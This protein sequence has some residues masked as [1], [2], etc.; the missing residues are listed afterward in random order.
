MKQFVNNFIHWN[1]ALWGFCFP[2]SNS[3]HGLWNIWLC[4]CKIDQFEMVIKEHGLIIFIICCGN[5]KF[6]KRCDVLLQ[7]FWLMPSHSTNW[8]RLIFTTDIQISSHS[9]T[10]RHQRTDVYGIVWWRK[11]AELLTLNMMDQQVKFPVQ[12]TIEY[13][14]MVTM[15]TTQV[16]NCT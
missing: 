3:H 8:T 1:C 10:K 4:I 11:F 16:G 15:E 13:L 2:I 6:K 5:V 14:A 12:F 7:K 9:V